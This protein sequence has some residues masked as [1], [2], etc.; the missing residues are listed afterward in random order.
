MDNI[1]RIAFVRELNQ[2][3]GKEDIVSVVIFYND[4]K[5][6][7]EQYDKEKH[8]SIVLKYAKAN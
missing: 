1:K 3:T 5:P 7:T 6:V 8:L 2:E 4:D